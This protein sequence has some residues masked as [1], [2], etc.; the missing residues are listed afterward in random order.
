MIMLFIN[1]EEEF[2]KLIEV[3]LF[4]LE[5]KLKDLGGIFVGVENF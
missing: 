5:M 3:M 2:V 1:V 4:L